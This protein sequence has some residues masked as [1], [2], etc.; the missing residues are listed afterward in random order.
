MRTYIFCFGFYG[1]PCVP[2]FLLHI[3]Q[4]LQGELP[5]P[6]ASVSTAPCCCCLLWCVPRMCHLFRTTSLGL[7]SDTQS[8][9]SSDRKVQFHGRNKTSK[10]IFLGLRTER[11]FFRTQPQIGRSVLYK[12]QTTIYGVYSPN[13]DSY[14]SIDWANVS[15]MRR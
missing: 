14:A 2:I 8:L 15:G 3:S 13:R 1:M 11:D 4:S 7:T 10:G 6:L 5:F 12:L 9:M